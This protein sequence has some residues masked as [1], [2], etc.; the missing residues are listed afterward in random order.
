MT[1]ILV[2]RKEPPSL[3]GDEEKKGT[4]NEELEENAY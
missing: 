3:I 4:R 2:F 1:S